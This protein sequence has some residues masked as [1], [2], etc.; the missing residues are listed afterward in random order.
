LSFYGVSN[1][2]TR[3]SDHRSGNKLNDC[4]GCHSPKDWG[5][6]A[7]TKK[8]A[9]TASTRS[10]IGTVVNAP[11]A[12]Q[13]A[14]SATAAAAAARGA[15]TPGVA[16]AA[17]ATAGTS[18]LSRANGAAALRGVGIAGAM[19]TAPLTHAGITNNCVS[20]H[21]GVLAPGKGATH[22]ASNNSC[23]NCH[24]TFAWMP[25][26][27]D[28]Q[29]VT[30]SC[31]SCHNGVAAPGKPARHVQTTQDCSA[32]HGTISW[33]PATF[34]HA[35][36]NATCQSCHNGIIATAKQVQ[37]VTTTLDC[38]SC[39][40]TMSWT[41]TAPPSK[42]KPLIPRCSARAG[43]AVTR[44]RDR[45]GIGRLDEQRTGR[46]RGTGVPARTLRTIHRYRRA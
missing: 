2:Q 22:I 25:A 40:N 24:T 9:A 31:A 34:S 8:V 23:E 21:N 26:R 28:H 13:N 10:T 37:H 3:P 29:G 6:G 30:A 12:T 43:A 33:S 38:G 17:V 20:C 27:F 32:C 41:V 42:L 19:G 36:V 39:H 18:L 14:A 44:S 35:G 15:A 1:L 4:N 7:A 46:T 11:A 45:D 5:G 16:T